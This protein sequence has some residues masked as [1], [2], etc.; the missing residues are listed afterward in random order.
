ML[1]TLNDSSQVS[2]KYMLIE[3][4]H[5]IHGHRSQFHTWKLEFFTMR[6]QSSS[7]T[8]IDYSE[9]VCVIITNIL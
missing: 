8:H 4:F 7:S 6:K 9:V 1:R 2:W 3:S 5:C